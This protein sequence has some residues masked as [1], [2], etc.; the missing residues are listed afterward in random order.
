PASDFAALRERFPLRV[1]DVFDQMAYE[2]GA[3]L[4]T[5]HLRSHGY[6]DGETRRRARVDVPRGCADVV[7]RVRPGPSA[8]FGPTEITGL[9]GI[10]RDVVTRELAYREG[11]I[12]DEREVA[13]TIRR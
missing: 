10:D 6:P 8:V 1:G 2:Q 13:E 9:E 7:Y 5:A 12:Y 4:L 11:E 3:A